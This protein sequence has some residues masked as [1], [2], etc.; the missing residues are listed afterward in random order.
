MAVRTCVAR[1]LVPGVVGNG[2]QQNGTVSAVKLHIPQ[3]GLTV[4]SLDMLTV[5]LI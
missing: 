5:T 3:A 4:D 2:M 1:N